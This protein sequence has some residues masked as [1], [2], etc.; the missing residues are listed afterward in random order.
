M[1]YL[2]RRTPAGKP[3]RR[4]PHGERGLKS[5]PP[6]VPVA[7][8]QSLPTRGA[9]IEINQGPGGCHPPVASLP[10]RGAWIE[11]PPS[12]PGPVL[13]RRSLPTRGAWIEI[14]QAHGPAS[15]TEG[16]SPHGER[17]LKCIILRSSKKVIRRSPHGE[18]GLKLICLIWLS[19]ASG[20]SPHGERGLKYIQNAADFD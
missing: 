20:R 13:P 8:G 17:G 10:T 1:K 16:R 9:W 4:S 5:H 7:G 14:H 3:S 11:M 18:R 12:A 19:L 2:R 6:D 15:G